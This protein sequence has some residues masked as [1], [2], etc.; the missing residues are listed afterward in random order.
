[1]AEKAL[2][3]ADVVGQLCGKRPRVASQPGHTLPSRGIAALAGMGC[4]RLLCDGALLGRGHHAV[5][6][7]IVLWRKRGV[8]TGP[9]GTSGPERLPAFVTA[10]PPMQRQDVA[11]DGVQGHPHPLLVRLGLHDAPPRIGF[12][13]QARHPYGGG[14]CRQGHVEGIRRRGNARDPTGSQPGE[15]ATHGTAQ[16]APR[17]AFAPQWLALSAVCGRTTPVH[18]LRRALTAAGCTRIMLLAMAG[19]PIVLVWR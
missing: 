10:I 19:L 5:I 14:A 9:Q 3:G 7:G 13:L 18:R 6:D 16:P 8:F 15:P 12:R 1:M 11:G 17:E 4:A 2:D